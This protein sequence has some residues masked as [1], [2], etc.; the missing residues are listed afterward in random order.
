M[1]HIYSREQQH[2]HPVRSIIEV[3]RAAEK[4]GEYLNPP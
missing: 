3:E 1:H 4:K 2:I